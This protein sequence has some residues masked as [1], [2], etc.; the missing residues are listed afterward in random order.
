MVNY[1]E[2]DNERNIKSLIQIKLMN[3]MT[4]MFACWK[5]VVTLFAKP[6]SI[7]NSCITSGKFPSEWKEV[8]IVST[9]KIGDKK[10]KKNNGQRYSFA[11]AGNYLKDYYITTY[12][13]LI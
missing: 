13:G 3:M 2:N 6:N 8:K 9:P 4:P 11:L 1:T 7:C 12:N 10:T 5:Y